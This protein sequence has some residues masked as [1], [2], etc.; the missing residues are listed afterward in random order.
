MQRSVSLILFVMLAMVASVPASEA[1]GSKPKEQAEVFQA[2][3]EGPAPI[4]D[5]LE[6]AE[7]Q[8]TGTD[9]VMQQAATSGAMEP[10]S[11]ASIQ[12]AFPVNTAEEVKQV[13]Q[14]LQRAGYDPGS[15]DG[16]W[17]PK[18]EQAVKEFQSA[19]G[20]TADGKVGPKTWAALV[21]SAAQSPAQQQ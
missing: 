17:G 19:K 12:I 8:Q 20:L 15:I 13:Q 3:T 4:G 21:S 9:L 10:S 1:M 2:T 7:S 5:A 18:T 6:Q 11:M 14:A 16:K